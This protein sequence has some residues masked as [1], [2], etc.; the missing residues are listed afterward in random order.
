MGSGK[1]TQARLF[2]E[3]LNDNNIKSIYTREIGGS[4]ISEKIRDL[5]MNNTLAVN[6]ELMMIM[7][8][9]YEHITRT[10]IP[11]LQ[12]NVWVICDRFI[13]ST[14]A[15]QTVNSNFSIDDIYHFHDLLLKGIYDGP[16]KNK[17]SLLPDLTFYLNIKPSLGLKRVK[18]RGDINKFDNYSEDYHYNIYNNFNIITAK[19]KDRIVKINIEE[20]Q[21]ISD[22]SLII[23]NKIINHFSILKKLG[24]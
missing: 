21:N 22:I 12:D 1:S 13:D 10:I 2:N 9:R 14:A 5:I 17:K 16:Y 4:Y 18:I 8:A 23:Q 24:K 15:Y 6:S 20:K 3:F 11:S 7:A 19:F